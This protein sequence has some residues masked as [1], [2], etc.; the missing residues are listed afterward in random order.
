M[1]RV[2]LILHNTMGLS[3]GLG[4]DLRLDLD[5]EFDD[6]NEKLGEAGP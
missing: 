6:W 1:I 2:R 4:L 3:L 5:R